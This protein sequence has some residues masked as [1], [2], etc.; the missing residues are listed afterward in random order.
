MN[1]EDLAHKAGVAQEMVPAW[2]EGYK[3][4]EREREAL[5]DTLNTCIALN[6]EEMARWRDVGI[7]YDAVRDLVRSY[8][9]EEISFGKLVEQLRLAA[10]AEADRIIREFSKK[11]ESTNNY[12]L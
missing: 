10:R 4:G 7:T 9:E 6:R 3:Y 8:G 11:E 5:Q 1:I 2:L 12:E